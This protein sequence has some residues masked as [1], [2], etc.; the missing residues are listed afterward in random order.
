M[1]QPLLGWSHK[2]GL[3]DGDV[4]GEKEGEDGGRKMKTS[5]EVRIFISQNEIQTG[6]TNQCLLA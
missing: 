3:E 6:H 4:L 5:R 1:R 2:S